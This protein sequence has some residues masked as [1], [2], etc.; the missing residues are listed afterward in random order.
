[1]PIRL[2]IRK[3]KSLL[4]LTALGA[5]LLAGWTFYDIYRGKQENRYQPNPPDHYHTLLMRDVPASGRHP[6][7]A[8]SASTLQSCSW[9]P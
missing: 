2:T 6:P 8:E 4:W 1:M 9:S 5:L 7:P 3:L